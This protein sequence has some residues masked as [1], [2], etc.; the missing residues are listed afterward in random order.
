VPPE[1]ALLTDRDIREYFY[2]EIRFSTPAHVGMH[3]FCAYCKKC[4]VNLGSKSS[5]WLNV[6]VLITNAPN[7]TNPSRMLLNLVCT[8]VRS[9][10]SV[11]S[12]L[13][14]HCHQICIRKEISRHG[15]LGV[16]RYSVVHSID[17][18]VLTSS[19]FALRAYFIDVQN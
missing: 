6:P 8:T 10:I 18:E 17:L 4:Q 19:F 12:F 9:L 7:S 3:V 13:L 11:G 1:L 15:F 16:S 14:T 2:T 5:G